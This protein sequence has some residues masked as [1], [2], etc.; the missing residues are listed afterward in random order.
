MYGRLEIHFSF[1]RQ[2]LRRTSDE[3]W[4][5]PFVQ[6][7]GPLTALQTSKDKSKKASTA[8]GTPPV[9]EDAENPAA[10]AKANAKSTGLTPPNTL[11]FTL[12]DRL[13]KMGFKMSMLQ[14]QYVG[15]FSL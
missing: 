6:T 5:D 8:N 12:Y 13:M 11:E 15:Y 7:G 14:V 9:S 1:H 4:V 3:R 2:S 10:L